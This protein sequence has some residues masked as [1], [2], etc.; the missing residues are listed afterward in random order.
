MNNLTG[1]IGARTMHHYV[2]MPLALSDSDG[3][4]CIQKGNNKKVKLV[5]CEHNSC[6]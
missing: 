1:H 4:V 6:Q 2:K 5:Q 3:A